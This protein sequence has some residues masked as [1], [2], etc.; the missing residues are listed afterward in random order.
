MGK[1]VFAGTKWGSRATY[2]HADP[3]GYFR[4]TRHYLLVYTLEGEA[5]YIDET[6]LETI[7]RP[8]SL[9][10]TVPGV[11]QSYG[12][13]AGVRWSEFYLWFSGPIF[14]AWQAAG[15]P[16]TRSL[17]LHLLP[18]EY[19]LER[20]RQL[21]APAPS[22]DAASAAPLTRL[23]RFQAMLSE[24]LDAAR[25]AGQDK[26]DRAWLENAC[27]RLREGGIAEPSLEEIARELNLSYSLFR[28]R[29]R[30]LTGQTPGEY[31]TGEVLRRATLRLRHGD[32]SIAHIAA[33]FGFCD[34]FHFS[35]RFKQ[36]T[37]MSPSEFRRQTKG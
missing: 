18:V 5:D 31:R 8:G 34:Q 20:F 27:R 15:W 32:E 24:A 35:R 25:T 4:P 12:P 14:D 19:W 26:S 36:A 21:L 17:H 1:V 30:Q 33:V 7:L 6:G 23:C 2:A 10:W 11:N 13:R 16:G 22:S 3:P 9:T 37:G 29:F 28:K